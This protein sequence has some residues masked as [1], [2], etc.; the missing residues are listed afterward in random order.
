MLTCLNPACGNQEANKIIK[1]GKDRQGRPR[2]KCKI[3]G[4]TFIEVAKPP[5]KQAKKRMK[6]E[7]GRPELYDE[8]KGKM[9]LSLTRTAIKGLDQLA[10]LHGVSRSEFVE[11]IGRG[12]ILVSNQE[13]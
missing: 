12:I 4:K 3:C 5:R 8:V 11:R 13:K 1:H 7:R 6:G 9:A 2:Y 10:V